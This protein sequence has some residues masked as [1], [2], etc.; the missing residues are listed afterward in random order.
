V[1]RFSVFSS[2]TRSPAADVDVGGFG[3]I[4]L[5]TADF[6]VHWDVGVDAGALDF[7]WSPLKDESGRDECLVVDT[8]VV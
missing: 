8:C 7:S 2:S 3:G 4:L 5:Y 1:T 6:G